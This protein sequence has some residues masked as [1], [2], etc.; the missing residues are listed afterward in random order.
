MGSMDKNSSWQL[1][2]NH[3]VVA[4]FFVKIGVTHYLERKAAEQ[5]KQDIFQYLP[6][7][8]SNRS[9]LLLDPLHF[10]FG[11]LRNAKKMSKMLNESVNISLKCSN[12]DFNL[13]LCALQSQVEYVG[14]IFESTLFQSYF[15]LSSDSNDSNNSKSCPKTIPTVNIM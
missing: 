14:K 8:S 13:E 4:F 3:Q 12:Y 9:N 10:R 15:N 6:Y 1:S 7:R 5:L 11:D 2:P